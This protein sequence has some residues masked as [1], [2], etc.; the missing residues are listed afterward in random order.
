MF[1]VVDSCSFVSG[2]LGSGHHIRP[3]VDLFS[4]HRRR[5]E[6]TGA[7]SVSL[8]TD[9]EVDQW[10]SDGVCMLGS[11]LEQQGGSSAFPASQVSVG[12]GRYPVSPSAVF[13]WVDGTWSEG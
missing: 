7:G 8:Q 9:E 13:V 2:T 6:L 4:R 3:R 12:V 11:A 5:A 1:G 10:A